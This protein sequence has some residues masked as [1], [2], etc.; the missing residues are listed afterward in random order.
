M[1]RKNII[2]LIQYS[3]P[4][5]RITKQ[6]REETNNKFYKKLNSLKAN[7]ITIKKLSPIRRIQKNYSLPKLNI[8]L[9]SI[10]NKEKEK[11]PLLK[12]KEK[13]NTILFNRDKYFNKFMTFEERMILNFYENAISQRMRAK[14]KRINDM[15][16]KQFKS[17]FQKCKQNYRKIDE[18]RLNKENSIYKKGI[19][20]YS[21]YYANFSNRIMDKSDLGL[22]NKIRLKIV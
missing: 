10:N 6:I 7:K 16:F 22:R 2:P 15:F 3:H 17:N 9:S 4:E 12:E 19:K 13:E 18:M 1:K 14:P 21:G 8:R 11:E 5:E 20:R